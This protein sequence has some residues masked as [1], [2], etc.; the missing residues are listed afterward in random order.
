MPTDENLFR[1]AAVFLNISECPS[2]RCGG[3]VNAVNH[4]HFWTQAILHGNHG[5]PLFR[6]TL[7]DVSFARF[8]TASMKPDHGREVL[9]S[10]RIVNVQY[11]CKL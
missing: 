7:G 2:D 11:L 6:K 1:C 10:N 3:I 8:Q 4:F 9:D 5:D